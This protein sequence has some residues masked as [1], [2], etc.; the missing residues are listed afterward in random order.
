MC[1]CVGRQK[2]FLFS[3]ILTIVDYN[4]FKYHYDLVG[5]LCIYRMYSGRSQGTLIPIDHGDTV[6]NMTLDSLF[7]EEVRYFAYNMG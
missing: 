1:A 3:L 4:G 6:H 2:E 7:S 5:S